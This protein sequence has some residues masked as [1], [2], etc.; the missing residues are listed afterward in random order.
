MPSAPFPHPKRADGH[1]HNGKFFSAKENY[2]DSTVAIFIPKG[3][4]E[5]GKIDFEVHFHGWSNHVEDVL[6]HYRLI[7]QFVASN[8][9]AVLVVP[10]GPA[11]RRIRSAASWK[12]PTASSVSWPT[13]PTRCDTN[14]P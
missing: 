5:T 6:D 9:N 8:R 10:Q 3:F 1:R 11:M 7:E 2:S 13:W 12:T 14:R 4:H